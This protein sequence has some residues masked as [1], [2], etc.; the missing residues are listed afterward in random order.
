MTLQ[1]S[2]DTFRDRTQA[3]TAGLRSFTRAR[4]PIG[5]I[6]GGGG[7]DDDDDDDDGGSTGGGSG[8]GG[9]G[10]GGSGGGGSVDRPD[11]IE[12]TPDIDVTSVSL[13]AGSYDPGDSATVSYVVE[14]S[15]DAS[16]S[17][18]FDVEVDGSAG[19][20]GSH[21]RDAGA[22]DYPGTTVT[23][24]DDPGGSFTVSIDGK[25]DSA[26]I[27]SPP[28]DIQ[29]TRVATDGFEFDAGSSITV[30]VDAKNLGGGAGSASFDVTVDGSRAGSVSTGSL[31]PGSMTSMTTTITVPDTPGETFAVSAGGESV[32]PL[33]KTEPSGGG[34]TPSI[35]INGPESVQAGQAVTY[36]VDVVGHE[37]GTVAWNGDVSGSGAEVA[38]TFESAGT[39]TVRVTADAQDGSTLEASLTVE[40][41][42][43]SGGNSGNSG[44]SGD[45]PE[46]DPSLVYVPEGSCTVP[47]AALSPG[48][49]I[50]AE[51]TVQND[52]QFE[53]EVE[54]IIFVNGRREAT[55]QH[56]APRGTSV[57]TTEL[58]FGRAGQFQ[59]DAELG[60]VDIS[61][62]SA[63]P[64]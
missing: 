37:P 10:G 47:G 31:S 30:T 22:S 57:A 44:N 51:A 61:P 2:L 7:G 35:S 23:V 49:T 1:D 64:P 63:A 38:T 16:G 14:N 58:T 13:G 26:S 27:A 48:D 34:V 20:Q 52:T 17:E 54:I 29:V 43:T 5:P 41:T 4:K 12:R 60:Q 25:S 39:K 53:A 6:G 36:F 24:P 59:I 45:E 15:G 9:S 19:G 42:G 11:P 50:Q 46:P 28:P 21:A 32:N 62:P 18:S 40:V 33:V 55:V 56:T 8:G 3:I